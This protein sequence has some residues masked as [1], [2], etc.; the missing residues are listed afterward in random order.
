MNQVRKI[1]KLNE[2]E[3][4]SNTSFSA[5]W[6]QDYRD[7]SYIFI[8]NLPSK[9]DE[10]DILTIFSQYGVPTAMKLMRDKKTGDS[11]KFAFL[12]Y[13]DFKSCVLAVDN[14][15][16]YEIVPG[17]ML[18]VD[19]VRYKPY[20]YSDGYDAN[21]KFDENVKKMLEEDFASDEEDG[22]GGKDKKLIK[23]QEDDPEL[24]DPMAAYF[25]EKEKES[26]RKSEKHRSSGK[27]SSDR[28]HSHHHRHRSS[29]SHRDDD[30]HKNSGNV[31]HSRKEKRSSRSKTD[32]DEESRS[33]R[34]REDDE[35]GH[36]E[37]SSRFKKR[38][39]HR[40]HRS[41][42]SRR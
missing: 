37:S 15:N 25:K 35:Y 22:D 2:Q 42:T 7:T 4:Q 21:L 38:T 17:C 39:S 5:S 9:L 13:E 41:S 30:K 40:G 36:R 11:L 8:G 1:E 33:K 32:R 14:L 23:D 19:H 26:A 20:K 28:H 10:E 24:E 34:D 16:G 6:H 12:K 27:Q 31:T 29:R 18:R 3:L